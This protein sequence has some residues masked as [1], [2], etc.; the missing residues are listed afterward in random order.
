MSKNSFIL[1]ADYLQKVDW[2]TDEQ[3]GI[4]F[5]AILCHENGEDMP[6]EDGAVKGAYMFIVSDLDKHRAEYEKKCEAR[7][8]AGK[9]G[10]RPKANETE[11]KQTKAKKANAFTTKQ[12]LTT[13]AD[14]DNENDNDIFPKGNNIYTAV[15]NSLNLHAGTMFSPKSD[16]TKRLID[17]RLHD[18]YD[19]ADFDKV[20]ETKCI[21]WKGTEM[22][23]FLR[24]QTLFGTKFESY[25]QQ[26]PVKRKQQAFDE[27]TYNAG[28]LEELVPNALDEALKELDDAATA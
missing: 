9:K 14:N 12:T 6:I 25:L 21:E 10:G 8:E 23:K 15:V 19:F 3:L 4:L 18:G 16:A 27:R 26:K 13:K 20:I 2:L 5:R 28:E 17:A 22:E 11:E 24:P 1:Y 7:S